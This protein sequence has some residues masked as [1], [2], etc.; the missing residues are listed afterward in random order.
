MLYGIDAFLSEENIKVH[1]DYVEKLKIKYSVCEV[2]DKNIA[3]RSLKELKNMRLGNDK[4][5]IIDL[6]SRIMCHEIFFDSFG[7]PYQSSKVIRDKYRTEANFLYEVYD[8]G[9]NLNC[10]YIVLYTYK[11]KLD[12]YYGREITEFFLKTTPILIVDMYEHAYFSDYGFERESYLEKALSY[13]N[14]AKVDNINH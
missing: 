7:K 13:W 11:N 2:C 10:G 1:K 4:M 8:K 9:R 5:N 14:L 6:K 12:I 3:G